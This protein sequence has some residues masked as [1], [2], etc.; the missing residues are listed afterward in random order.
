MAIE[1]RRVRTGGRWAAA[2]LLALAACRATP[3][4]AFETAL[5]SAVK[6]RLT[7]RGASDRNP[8]P[9]TEENVR[10]G[11]RAFAGYCHA[12]H[13]LDGQNTGVPFASAMSPPVPSL[14]SPAVQAYTDGQLKWVIE[15]G[16]YP[17]GMPAARGILADEEIWRIV[18]FLRHLPPA[19]SLGEPAA[20]GGGPPPSP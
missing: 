17:S 13:G 10:A 3:P 16:L 20:Y 6:R 9:P 2:L 19:G 11:Q 12:C 4:S 7:V 1:R 5:A 18:V 15:N 14:S 8:L